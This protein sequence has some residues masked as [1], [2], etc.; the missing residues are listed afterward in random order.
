MFV[1]ELRSKLSQLV[2]AMQTKKLGEARKGLLGS[3]D[4]LGD[5]KLTL[6]QARNGW[7]IQREDLRHTIE[8]TNSENRVLK[9]EVA[10]L[11][12]S[13]ENREAELA[14][15]SRS[16]GTGPEGDSSL[17]VLLS[18]S[19]SLSL[20]P[21]LCVSFCLGWACTSRAGAGEPKARDSRAAQLA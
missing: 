14:R 16:L 8:Q 1:E 10:A 18:L 20:A 17:E 3:E 12:L 9:S 11:T 4:E 19:L 5:V 7:E 6:E 21:T 15:W 2:R 13:L